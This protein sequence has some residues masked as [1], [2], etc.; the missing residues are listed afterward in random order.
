MAEAHH[1]LKLVWSG[2]A[3]GPIR[4]YETFSREFRVDIA[5]KPPLYGSTDPFYRGDPSLYTPEDLLLAAVTGCYMLGYVA[6]CARAGVVVVSYE[7]APLATLARQ[8]GRTRFVDVLLRPKVVIESGSDMQKAVALHE[9][10]HSICVIANSVNFPVRYEPEVT[11]AA[12]GAAA[13]Q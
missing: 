4:S 13:A 7:D 10:A 8:E 1:S 12:I 9:K 3:Q 6:L 5:G 11:F 2:G